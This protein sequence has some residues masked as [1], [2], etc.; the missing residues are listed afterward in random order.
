MRP[1]GERG[2]HDRLR[3]R[4]AFRALLLSMPRAFR[5]AKERV[6]LKVVLS[7]EADRTAERCKELS[8][9]QREA[10]NPRLQETIDPRTPAGVRGVPGYGNRGCRSLRS[11]NPRA[12]LLASLR[13]AL[14]TT[15]NCNPPR[16]MG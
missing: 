3:P 2:C 9:G 13:G 12:K 16:N 5:R 1:A 4:A 15:L 7:F 6:Q 10:R 11:L 14:S 8:R